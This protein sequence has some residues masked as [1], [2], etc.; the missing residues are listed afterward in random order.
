MIMKSRTADNACGTIIQFDNGILSKYEECA[1]LEG[2]ST[3]VYNLFSKTPARA[4]FL[5]SSRTEAGYIGDY[6]SRMIMAY[7]EISFTYTNNGAKVYQSL[8]D[9]NLEN[10]IFCVYGK[11][12][13]NKLIRVDYEDGQ[14]AISGYIGAN[15]LNFSNKSRISIFL[16]RRYIRSAALNEAIISAYGSKLM[17]GKFPFAVLNLNV[18]CSSVDVNVH[19]T[20]LD[21]RFSDAYHVCE[22]LTKACL[23][24][25][26]SFDA[27]IPKGYVEPSEA[28]SNYQ[29]RPFNT[30]YI[31][32]V[33]YTP[34]SE[35]SSSYKVKKNPDES[36]EEPSEKSPK[37]QTFHIDKRSY[38]VQPSETA[39]VQQE[40]LFQQDFS[41]VG[42]VFSGYWIVEQNDSI[43]IIDQHAAHERLLYE[44]LSRQ[45]T[46]L[47][48]QEL[49][50]PIRVDINDMESAVFSKYAKELN[51]FGYSF[52]KSG[53]EHS[54][55]IS[56][57]PVINGI[58]LSPSS[59]LD[60]LDDLSLQQSISPNEVIRKQV[61]QA[62]CKHAVKVNERISRQEIEEL[63]HTFVTEGI[64]TTCP[65]GRPVM[66]T[67]SKTDFEKMFKRITE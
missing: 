15:D 28:S 55:M 45:D 57:V 42:S 18:N 2:T 3:E 41:I 13:L 30:S 8:G 4:K 36:T 48:S 51:A 29:Y 43:Y 31:D 67:F 11:D 60:I 35:I 54:L 19:P 56:S 6:I 59:I 21:V 7:P 65:H 25:L 23:N 49:I 24:A 16:N 63:I 50:I 20:K 47:A 32:K 37:I 9:S 62:S 14:I 58:S 33:K 66:I 5:K 39:A 22:S 61:V 40:P 17:S 26:K 1:C 38:A 46:A 12:I 10:S 34:S 44:K 53:D 64:P 52:Q 27:Y